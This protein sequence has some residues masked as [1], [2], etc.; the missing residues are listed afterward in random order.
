M[1]SIPPTRRITLSAVILLTP[2]LV[3]SV[4]YAD[5]TDARC[6]IYP[7][8]E[9]QASASVPCVFSQRQGHVNIDRS[10]GIA[11][12]LIPYG[13]NPGNYQDQDGNMAYRNSG[14]GEDGLIFRMS[15]ESVYVYWD[16]SGLPGTEGADNYAAPYST[17]DWDATT[18]LNCTLGKVSDGDC[19]AG[20]NRGPGNRQ[21]VIAIMRPDGVER[22][23]QFD[24]DQV[25]SPGGGEIQ[26][27]LVG[28]DWIIKIDDEE[29][30]RI[31]LAAPEGG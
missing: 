4:T 13:D 8:G 16:T 27:E 23:L 5:W 3:F 11:H 1:N 2:M 17:R 30:Y 6:D 20:I 18:R 24:G 21:A 7:K 10:D 15:D 22:V 19:A 25:V 14:L 28:D 9:D 31:P 26:A 12:D 29:S